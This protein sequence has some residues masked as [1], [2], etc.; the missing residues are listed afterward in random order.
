MD[1]NYVIPFIEHFYDLGYSMAEGT[2]LGFQEAAK[3]INLI[4]AQDKLDETFTRIK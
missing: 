3:E 4:I 2:Y 1:I